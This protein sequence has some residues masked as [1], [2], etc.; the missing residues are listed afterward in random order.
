MKP[1]LRTR[2]EAP[3]RAV[4]VL[5][6]VLLVAMLLA[7]P[8]AVRGDE[9]ARTLTQATRQQFIA[10]AAGSYRLQVIAQAPKGVV[11]DTDGRAYSLERYTRGKITLLSFMYTYCT[12]A[13]GCPLAFI[14]LHGLR[15]RLL[16]NPALARQV[17]FV[18]LSF[19]PVNDTPEAMQ[20]YA[21][22]LSDST[23][24]LRWHFLTTSSVQQLK[25]IIDEL[26]QSVQVQRDSQGKPG[27]LYNHMLKMFLL[28]T[29]GRVR[30][31]Y[32]SAFLQGDVMLNDVKTLALEPR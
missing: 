19:D 25:P 4:A 29:K 26:G 23:S 1:H 18:S 21:G 10:P 17:R 8:A 30:E 14:T 15:E 20:R 16:T 24:L 28:D 2:L 27:R 7:F 12:D 13:I 6:A 22:H 11:Q 32:S 9:L 3:M 5:V 31:I